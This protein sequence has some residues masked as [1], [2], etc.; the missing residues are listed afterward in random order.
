MKVDMSALGRFVLGIGVAFV[1]NVVA[2]VLGPATPSMLRFDL[3]FRPMLLVLLLG[4]FSMLLIV[5]DGVGVHPLSALGLGINGPWRRDIRW[6]LLLGGGMVVVPVLTMAAS[7]HMRMSAHVTA[8]TMLAAGGAVFA[9]ATGAMAEEV[10]FRGYPFQ[11]LAEGIGS[12]GAVFVFAVLFG[13]VHLLNPHASVWG[14]LNTV[15]IGVLLSLAYLRTRS[16]WMPWGI[17]LGWNAVLGLVLGLPVSG[18]G[19]FSVIVRSQAIGPVWLTG[20]SYGV[21]ASATAAVVVVVGIYVLER[22]VRQRRPHPGLNA[23]GEHFPTS[24]RE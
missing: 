11:R 2:G 8:R 13:V 15:L 10:M 20:G 1:A 22:F 12:P 4:G 17:H 19:E 23:V 6:G 7:G 24:G 14:L 18:L 16:L 9:L 3:F 5:V 21:E